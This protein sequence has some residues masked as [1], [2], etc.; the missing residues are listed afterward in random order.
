MF[1][2]YTVFTGCSDG[3]ARAFDAKSGSLKR[4]FHG[5]ENSINCLCLAGAKLYTGSQDGSLRVWNAAKIG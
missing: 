2:Y 4:V 5:H 3:I 1:F